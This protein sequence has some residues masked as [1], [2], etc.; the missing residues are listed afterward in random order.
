MDLKNKLVRMSDLSP[1]CLVRMLVRNA[2]VIAAAAVIFAMASSLYL[3]WFRTPVYQAAMTYAVISRQSS[4][5]T[6]VSITASKEVAA[7][8]A[9]LFQDDVV[10]EKLPS[11]HAELASFDGTIQA[12]QVSETNLITVTARASSPEQA[13]LALDALQ[14]LF[15]EM[16]NYLSSSS[17]AQVIRNPA[18]S[19]YP[20]NGVNERS[21]ALRFAVLGAG[22]MMALLLWISI[23][24]ETVQTREGARRLLD[25]PIVATV[26]HERKNRTLRAAIKRANKGIQVF[27]PTTSA[28]YTEQINSIATRLEQEQAARGRRIFLITG[29]G[30]NEGKSTI[31]ANVASVLAMKGRKVAIVDGDLRKPAMRK[32]FDGAY[33]T[34]VPMDVL[35][36]NPY[37]RENFRKCMV[38]HKR[39]GLY[40]FFA[41][42]GDSR[43]LQL[44]TGETMRSVLNEMQIFDFV[45]IDTPPMGFFPDAE[46]A[47]DLADASLLV[48]RQDYTPACDINDAADTLR[49]AKSHFLG[50]VLNDM[51]SGRLGGYGYGY[52]YGYG[53]GYG[54]GYG[55]RT[56]HHKKDS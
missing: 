32:F 12:E 56:G 53:H 1:R 21:Y 24:R 14:E 33:Q 25:A 45:I 35:L 23:A 4:H 27:A 31:A 51:D 46:A 19:S 22:G 29:V 34:D 26:G 8:M 7:V 28:A 48:V 54:Y 11:I 15:P 20:V 44:L 41:A 17:M 36:K 2:W 55:Q 16:S 39:L 9:E 37:T 10:R 49:K 5:T 13:F 42:A 38:R 43:S 50:C 18:V 6:S 3:S 52:G 47:A 30:E 40:M